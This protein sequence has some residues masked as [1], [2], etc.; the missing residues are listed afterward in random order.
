MK[1]VHG[2]VNGKKAKVIYFNLFTKQ[3]K[4]FKTEVKPQQ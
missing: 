4:V 1:L 2:T 3:H